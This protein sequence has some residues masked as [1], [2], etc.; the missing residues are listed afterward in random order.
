MYVND[1]TVDYGERGRT[2]VHE[3]FTR[4]S[5]AGLLPGPVTLQFIAA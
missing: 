1:Y 4:A 5:R 3:L 2:A